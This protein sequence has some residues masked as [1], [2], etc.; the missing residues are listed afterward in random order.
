MS[1]IH[2]T[3]ARGAALLLLTPF[4]A[5]VHA[6][7]FPT[8]DRVLYVRDCLRENPGPQFEMISKCSCAVDRLA[9]LVKY[10]DYVTM[11]TE[12]NATS[13]SG[14]RGSTMRDNEAV[15]KDAKKYRELQAQVKSSCFIGMGPK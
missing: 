7:D 12:A 2:R 8:M 1:S 4:G 10:D 6:N 13:I 5:L 14:E 15:Q 3:L 9:E 11:S